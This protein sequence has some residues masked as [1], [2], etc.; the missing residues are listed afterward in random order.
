MQVLTQFLKMETLL[1]DSVHQQVELQI[2][3]GGAPLTVN[4]TVRDALSFLGLAFPFFLVL[5]YCLRVCFACCLCALQ[6]ITAVLHVLLPILLSL[7]SS[8]ST[9]FSLLISTSGAGFTLDNS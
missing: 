3:R 7:F 2:E 5:I 1:D 4:V 9:K 8:C 6:E